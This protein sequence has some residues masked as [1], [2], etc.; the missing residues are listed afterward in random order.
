MLPV[1]AR[2]STT[3]WLLRE[4]SA[5]ID[6]PALPAL[7][8]RPRAPAPRDR[9]PRALEPLLPRVEG[10]SSPVP[11]LAGLIA[12]CPVLGEVT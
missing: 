7:P 6:D 11:G 5:T 8:P 2:E 12:S 1:A 3:E 4:E 10:A 9:P